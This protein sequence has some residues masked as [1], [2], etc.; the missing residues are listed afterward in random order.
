MHKAPALIAA[1]LLATLFSG[2]GPGSNDVKV[3]MNL[4]LTGDIPAVGASSRNAAELFFDQLNKNGGIALADGPKKVALVI[5]DNGGKADQS[6]SVAQQLISSQNVVAMVGPNSSA[7]AIP[8][9]EI[10]ESLKCVMISPW[11]TNPKTTLDQTTGAP[12]RYVF[13]GCF[14]DPF[15]AIVLAKFVLNDLGGKKAA[16]LYDVSSEA[17]LGQATLFKDT[18]TANGGE[19]VAFETFTTGDKDFSAQ[20]TNIRAAN[21]DVI[22]LPTYYNDV[23]LIAQQARRLGITVPLI[24][25]DAWSSP[26]IIKLGGADVEG[27]YFCN[28]FSTQIATDEAKK[29]IADYTA[30]YKQAP[31][32]VAALTFDACGLIAEALKAGGK[33]DREALRGALSNIREFKGVTGTFR[34]EPGSG[35]PIKSAVVLQIKD[36]AFQWVTNAQP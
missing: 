32:D 16:V 29:F 11:S 5:R 2:C 26:E 8:A 4:E 12:K 3:G 17:P 33:N 13:R 31:D 1:A 21:P 34:F 18:F 25:S 7:C 10:A 9:G 15:Q 28:H 6:A 36:G 30:K 19:I 27:S 24:G 35:D 20:L 23:P 22:F 14:T